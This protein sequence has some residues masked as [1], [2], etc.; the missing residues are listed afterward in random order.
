[1][2]GLFLLETPY[3][4]SSTEGLKYGR[5]EK[6]DFIGR[7]FV[8]KNLGSPEPVMYLLGSVRGVH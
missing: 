4:T 3:I 8:P 1:M 6:W 7:E 5:K 2:T